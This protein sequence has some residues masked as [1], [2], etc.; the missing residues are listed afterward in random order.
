M[1]NDSTNRR[2]GR[3]TKFKEASFR[4][5]EEINNAHLLRNRMKICS[6]AVC[7]M[8]ASSLRTAAFISSYAVQVPSLHMVYETCKSSAHILLEEETGF[9]Q[10]AN[11]Q[12]EQCENE[13]NT[14]IYI[15]STRVDELSS[16][17]SDIVFSLREVAMN[18]TEDGTSLQRSLESW[19]SVSQEIPTRNDTCSV[20]DREAMFSTIYDVNSLRSEAVSV[21]SNYSQ[22]STMIMGNIVDYAKKRFEYDKNYVRSYVKDFELEFM[23]YIGKTPLPS[24]SVSIDFRSI[25]SEI[26]R[27]MDCSTLLDIPYLSCD[28]FFPDIKFGG[29][30]KHQTDAM[31]EKWLLMSNH[32]KKSYSQMM[33]KI[34]DFHSMAKGAETNFLKYWNGKDGKKD[35]GLSNSLFC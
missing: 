7:L 8:W 17:N 32:W 12:L 2:G 35:D 34:N 10:C 26:E 13:L 1:V 21:F 18:C 29:H 22:E 9:S 33:L 25:T 14:A 30:W 5:K 3:I 23:N 27:L 11:R 20:K 6:L 16:R 24:F 28:E 4:Y 15:E 19:L 31:V